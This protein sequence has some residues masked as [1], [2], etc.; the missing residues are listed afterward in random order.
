M[1]LLKLTGD[2]GLEF[3]K[4]K[5]ISLGKEVTL[6]IAPKGSRELLLWFLRF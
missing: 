1:E 5:A 2:M 6:F 4:D 3:S